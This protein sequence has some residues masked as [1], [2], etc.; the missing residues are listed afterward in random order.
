MAEAPT[1][2]ADA[3]YAQLKT[4]LQEHLRS[5]FPVEGRKNRLVLKSLEI[6]DTA[7]P[8]DYREQKAAKMAGQSWTVPVIGRFELR[9]MATNKLLDS[10]RMKIVDL[11]RLTNRGSYIVGGTE[12]MFPIQKRLR[13]GPYT[14]TGQDGVLRTFFNLAKGR[15]FHLGMH[16]QKGHFQF[17]VDSSR[18]IFLYPLLR[19]L[20]VTNDEMKR[21]WG[22]EVFKANMVPDPS[23]ATKA[24][25]AVY[26]KMSYGEDPP[27]ADKL[28]G[29]VRELF[30]GTKMDGENTKLTLGRPADTVDGKALLSATKKILAVSQGKAVE[31]NRDS[32]VHNDIVDL[33]DFV[34]ERFR[35]FQFRNRIARTIR[36]NI[37]RRDKVSQIISRDAF[38]RPVDS[39]FTE[40]QLSQSP[41]QTN[42]LGM[43]SDYT[44]VTVRG[45]GGIQQENALTRSV[46][47]LDP[48]HLG[49][50]DPAHTP[51]GSN[52]GT[53]MHLT[54]NTRKK[55]RSLVTRVLNA[56][57]GRIEELTPVEIFK[58]TVAFP[59]FV[60]GRKLVGTRIKAHRRG[61]VV[62]VGRREVDYAFLIPEH[63]VDL[64]TATIPFTSHNN[65]ARVMLASKMGV[66][67][68]PLSGAES[69][70]VQAGLERGTV[71]GVVGRAFSPK[72]PVDG[73]VDKVGRDEIVV[74]GKSVKIPNYFP[75]NSNNFLHARPR[76]R[77]GDRVKKGQVLADTNYTKDG[78]LA[79]GKNLRVAY[80]PFK[81]MNVE[82]GIVISESAAEKMTSEHLY[83]QSYPFDVDT[84]LSLRKFMAYFPAKITNE[85]ARALDE[86]GVIKKGEKV[87]FGTVLVASMRKR[88]LGTESQRMA[89]IS[90]ILAKDYRDDSLVWDK[91]V[92]GVVQDVAKRAKEIVVH[93]R[94]QEPMRI[95]DKV[96][97]RYGN[98]GIVVHIMPDSQMPKDSRGRDMEMLLNPNGV[99]SRMNLGQI[100]ETT[101]SR[102]AEKTG[103]PYVTRGFG[104]NSAERI[105]KDLKKNKVKD[106]DT[107]FDPVENQKIPGVLTGQQYIYKLEHQA[108]K[109]ISARGGG[110]EEVYSA[111]GQPVRGPAG[112]RGIGSMELYAMLGHGA[113]SNVN[114]MYGIKSDFDPEVWRAIESGA[115]LPPPRPSHSQEKFRSMLKAMGVNVD[116]QGQEMAMVPFL[117]RDVKKVSAGEITNHR[118]LRGKDLREEKNGLFDPKRTGGVQGDRWTHIKLPEPVPNPTFEKAVLSLLHMKKAEFDEIMAGRK[119]VNGLTGGQA[120]KTMLAA[121]DVDKRLREAGV[122]IQG[123]T[124]SKLNALHRE[125][126]FLRALKAGGIKPQEYVIEN[127][128]VLPPKFRPVYVMGDGNLNVSDVNLHYQSVLQISDQMK[129]MKG[130]EFADERRK[131][132]GEL[133]KSVAGVMGFNDGVV[134]RKGVR[135]LARSISGVGSPKGG[136]FQSRLIK[137]RQDVSATSVIVANPR[138]GIDEVGVPEAL[139]W[140][141]F[142]PFLVRELR[143]MG[144]TPLSAKSAIDERT[145]QARKALEN[146]M[147]ERHVILNRAPT[148]HK[149]SVMAFKPRL[150]PGYA[151]EIPP[152]VVG[153]FNADFDG[154]TMGLHVPV[155][156]EANSEA[157]KMLP[158]KHLYKPG[159]KKLQPKIEHEYVLGLFKISRMG[160]ATAKRYQ[161]L[162]QVLS[163]LKARKIAPDAGISVQ[164][165]VGGTTPGRVLINEALPRKLRD[166]Q[167]VWT[168]KN[169]QRKLVEI[170][171]E[172]G[173][174][175][176]V[177][178]LQRLADIGR[179]YAYLTGSSFLLSDLQTMTSARNAAYRRADLQ[180]DRIRRGPG[181]DDEKRKKIIKVYEG[182]GA[183]LRDQ[184]SMGPNA[185]RA[186]N[187]I[188]DMMSAGARGNP[189]QVMQMV[190]SVGVML[191]HENKPMPEPVRG[192]YTEGL[193]TS[194][195]FQH[196]Y[197]NRKG[198][199]DRS[200]SVKD[201]GALTKQVIVSAAG[202]RVTM[203]DC[204]TRNGIME[205]TSGTNALDRY[206]AEGVK[207]LARRGQL[208]TTELL[209]SLRVKGVH[210]IKVRSAL[211][212]QA[213]SGVCVRCYGLNEEGRPATLGEHT[214]IKDTQGLTEPST[215][216]AMKTFHTGG[217]SAGGG[218]LTSGFDRVKQLFTMP[219]N[220]AQAAVLAEVGGSV[221]SVTDSPF[222]GQVVVVAGVKHKVPRGRKP[223][224]K[225]GDRVEKG[226]RVSDG[227][228]KPQDMLRL[229]GLRAMQMQLRDDV[230]QVYADGKEQIH[231]KTIETPVRILTET[232]RVTDPGDHPSL[233]TGDYSTYGQVDSWNR[234]HK[235]RRPV[236][237]MHVLPGAE[238]LPHKSDDW[239]LRMAH[240]RIGQ[241][242]QEA[243]AMG[244]R[245][246][247]AGGSPFGPLVFGR[248]I[249]KDPWAQGGLTSG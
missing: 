52:V 196:M 249:E 153:G 218:G 222:G 129:K 132:G 103:K 43:I 121:I 97:G 200:Q 164:G 14:R 5:L 88:D 49:F 70:L 234:G 101:A 73:V 65:G 91:R 39:L 81:G 163:D 204:Q 141:T 85:Q 184:I 199:I 51:E 171:E 227:N 241:V 99:V 61:E 60:K 118:I 229:N 57:T 139:A 123:K 48:S 145:P 191:D 134:E 219:E 87:E 152:L 2:H 96:V 179:R 74:S 207:G 30:S 7:D 34:V 248:K 59:E 197:G 86:D 110:P 17:Q 202:Y 26:S 223:V 136:Y 243:P 213:P 149:F 32:L 35:D 161:S 69:P 94:T 3:T 126:R 215:Q 190:S 108:T 238:Q 195:F 125:I 221:E 117:D 36:F 47:A 236:R 38:Q 237:Y 11:P 162:G 156:E 192:T 8:W 58:S 137:K 158:S 210:K 203:P 10:S 50:L 148:L 66:Q 205:P 104:E 174:Q 82:D 246:Q 155:S 105:A 133:Y 211:T 112:G 167:L 24:L 62:T 142:R 166:Y 208:V 107:L 225:V 247:L 172:E 84:V 151:I 128:P 92:T 22:S 83:Q 6:R 242:L 31:D 67:A 177:R 16:P 176:F 20:G 206:L 143:S 37:D 122:E 140:K 235:G 212:C 217:V 181:S 115:P 54:V 193:S 55:G 175:A 144:M 90:R 116:Q 220:I 45:E 19:A 71:E 157:S 178:A 100:L 120:I 170:D 180:A 245:A 4:N 93:V 15:N 189:N 194:E 182:V 23:V 146:V 224:V 160:R 244:A 63:L 233:V 187:N 138:L 72:S 106:H 183:R 168:D 240:N 12:Y 239:A 111:E 27:E 18:N 119:S 78:D 40:A 28:P 216:L 130:R 231:A 198:M 1:Q 13:S 44:A 41:T 64:N 9:D 201:P 80:V 131:L 29:A 114:E 124:G 102:I 232:V 127:L 150:V 109:K 165:I 33:A 56:R 95:G 46:R 113:V 214:G 185:S 209:K 75:L 188:M 89:R 76:V 79:L 186:S 226:Q 98:K 25:Q 173:R 42:P 68:K 135:G 228:I 77:V 53:T 154:D 159:S 169:I 147:R 21:A 230:Q